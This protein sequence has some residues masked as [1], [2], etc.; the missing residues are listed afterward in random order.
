FHAR[1]KEEMDYLTGLSKEPEE[2]ID[3]MLYLKRLTVLM[4]RLDFLRVPSSKSTCTTI[5]HAEEAFDQALA[6]VEESERKIEIVKRW[7]WESKDL[8]EA[9]AVA[10]T[11]KYRMYINDLEALVLK[12]MF[13]LTKITMSGTGVSM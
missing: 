9:S 2:E 7:E 6:D 12:H 10:D 4:E 13:E 5:R 8:M 3:Q 11:R 1:L